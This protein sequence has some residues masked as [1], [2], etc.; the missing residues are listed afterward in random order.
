M[1]DVRER[2]TEVLLPLRAHEGPLQLVD[3]SR[4][5]DDG[6]PTGERPQRGTVVFSCAPRECFGPPFLA[7][8]RV[9]KALLDELEQ[10]QLIFVE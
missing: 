8:Q 1:Q 2:L 3:E 9:G 5:G 4:D 7:T 6:V 10:P